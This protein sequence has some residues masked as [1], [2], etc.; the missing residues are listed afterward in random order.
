MWLIFTHG[1][2]ALVGPD[3]NYPLLNDCWHPLP[4][5]TAPRIWAAA[6]MAPDGEGSGGKH[7]AYQWKCWVPDPDRG[8]SG[9]AVLLPSLT[10]VGRGRS[11]CPPK[12]LRRLRPSAQS[13]GS[14]PRAF[15]EGRPIGERDTDVIGS[16]GSCSCRGG[17]SDSRGS[18]L[19]SL[20]SLHRP[21]APGEAPAP[22]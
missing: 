9:S 18:G 14:E 3:R 21:P 6:A 17:D 20:L 7:L 15:C 4:D 12:V 13:V 5:G 11:H 22:P 8:W 16:T 10:L 19:V 2:A 1:P